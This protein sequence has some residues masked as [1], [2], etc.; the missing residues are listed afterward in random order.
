[1]T[2]LQYFTRSVLSLLLIRE[3]AT[4]NFYCLMLNSEST[5]HARMNN[6]QYGVSSVLP[7]CPPTTYWINL[8]I[9][10]GYFTN[11]L[12]NTEYLLW[13]HHPTSKCEMVILILKSFPLHT[14]SHAWHSHSVFTH[15]LKIVTK[16][17][18]SNCSLTQ[19]DME[20]QRVMR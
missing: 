9:D 16:Y 11:E 8:M 13:L 14:I 6:F 20:H 5:S 12:F 3:R 19:V 7:N 2:R 1:M 17:Y 10:K 15:S 18:F 4:W